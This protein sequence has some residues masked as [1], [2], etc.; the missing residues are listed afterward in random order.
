VQPLRDQIGVHRKIAGGIAQQQ[1][2]KGRVIVY[3][4]AAIAI[5]DLAARR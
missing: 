1:S 3:N 5:E 2:G 4:D